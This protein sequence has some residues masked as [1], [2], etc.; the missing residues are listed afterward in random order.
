M[1][2]VSKWNANKRNTNSNLGDYKTVSKNVHFK[3][4]VRFDDRLSISFNVNCD[5]I[6]N[7]TVK[8][9]I[10]APDKVL[11]SLKV[12]SKGIFLKNKDFV[13]KDISIV[14]DY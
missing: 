12:D 7:S 9:I 6:D 11:K 5:E 10:S 8:V 13:D 2:V 3:K 4:G 14:I 1:K